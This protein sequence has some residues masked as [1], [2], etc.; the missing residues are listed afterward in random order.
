MSQRLP[1]V[2]GEWCLDTMSAKALDLSPEER[3]HYFSTLAD[4]QLKS[5]NK[6]DGW[7]F[8]SYKLQVDGA[9]LDGWDLRKSIELGYLPAGLSS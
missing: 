8:W 9:N 3:R 6:T 1:L 4:A 2:V 5:W 7:F